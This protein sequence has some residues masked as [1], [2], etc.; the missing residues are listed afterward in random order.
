MTEH[1]IG[2]RCAPADAPIVATSELSWDVAERL[3]VGHGVLA[4]VG[5]CGQ[6]H[7][8]EVHGTIRRRLHRS[9]TA[10]GSG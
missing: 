6:N 2:A 4:R 5:S 8:C 7:V 1:W 3:C 9:V 10:S